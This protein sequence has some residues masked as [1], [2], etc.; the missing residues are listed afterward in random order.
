MGLAKKTTSMH[1]TYGVPQVNTTLID[2]SSNN[3]VYIWSLVI[4]ADGAYDI[5]F[6]SSGDIIKGNGGIMG[7]VGI[8][9][10]GLV[11]EIV[12][13]TCDGNT[14]VRIMFDEV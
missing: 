9:K 11:D 5:H 1:V 2:P 12:Q 13:I 6:L 4:E 7:A 3:Y 14:T 10:Q 8:N